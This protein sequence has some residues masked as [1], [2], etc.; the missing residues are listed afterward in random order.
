MAGPGTF[1]FPFFRKAKSAPGRFNRPLWAP[2]LAGPLVCA[3]C[4]FV[5]AGPTGAAPIYRP[6]QADAGKTVITEQDGDKKATKPGEKKPASADGREG[7]KK[8]VAKKAP[9]KGKGKRGRKKGQKKTTHRFYLYAGTAWANERLFQPW[10]KRFPDA[11]LEERE[12]VF[13]LT[14]GYGHKLLSRVWQQWEINGWWQPT[15][16]SWDLNW[17]LVYVIFRKKDFPLVVRAKTGLGT[18]RFAFDF[19]PPAKWSMLFNFG[20]QLKIRWTGRWFTGIEFQ[21]TLVRLE[22]T[23]Y[24]EK[25]L[26]EDTLGIPDRQRVNL[27]TGYKW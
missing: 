12:P 21:E 7:G 23:P 1:R 5:L 17:D 13:P 25:S 4:L 2:K 11:R 6:N 26:V 15:Y 22:R 9:G 10:G 18:A 14:L 3:V 20:L 24:S 8:A 16:S 19:G 27:I